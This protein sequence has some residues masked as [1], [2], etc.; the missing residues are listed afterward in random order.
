MLSV[1]PSVRQLREGN[2]NLQGT[3]CLSRILKS[4]CNQCL[5]LK[6]QVFTEPSV[7]E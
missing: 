3:P 6:K 2:R 5:S 7:Q 1:C 4:G